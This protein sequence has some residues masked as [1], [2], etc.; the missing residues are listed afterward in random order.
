[1]KDLKPGSSTTRGPCEGGRRCEHDEVSEVC[2]RGVI[3]EELFHLL[4]GRGREWPRPG[5]TGVCK[6]GRVKEN[7]WKH[8]QREK[9]H[10]SHGGLAAWWIPDHFVTIHLPNGTTLL[11]KLLC[12]SHPLS[13]EGKHYCSL[14]ARLY[15]CCYFDM[16]AFV[17][18][19]ERSSKAVQM[20]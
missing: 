4:G 1:M 15:V 10:P 14:C 17:C 13:S 11:S 12:K 6:T 18:A 9:R 5:R 19:I 2:W 3:M 16:C 20:V 7:E 8:K